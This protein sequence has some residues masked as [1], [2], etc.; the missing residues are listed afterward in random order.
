MKYKLILLSLLSITLTACLN[1]VTK[2]YDGPKKPNSA[3]AI[4][5]NR[6]T[7]SPVH[8]YKVDSKGIAA[9]IMSWNGPKGI[10]EIH[11]LPEVHTVSGFV[12]EGG[13][14]RHFS[15]KFKFKAGKKYEIDFENTL[16]YKLLAFV[17]VLK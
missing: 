15:I 12:H 14:T 5:Y 2:R 11:L 13:E 9:P 16:D 1:L 7:T 6:A 3:I 8:I 4:L 10:K 17:K